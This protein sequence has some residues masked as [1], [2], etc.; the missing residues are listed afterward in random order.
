[1]QLSFEYRRNDARIKY[2]EKKLEKETDEYKKEILEIDLDEKIY[3]RATMQ[4]TARDRMREIKLWSKIKKEKIAMAERI[5]YRN[6]TPKQLRQR[7]QNLKQM[8]TEQPK[9]FEMSILKSDTLTL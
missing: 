7:Q 9:G 6:S 3:G 8:W 2:L 4:L 5:P 1:M